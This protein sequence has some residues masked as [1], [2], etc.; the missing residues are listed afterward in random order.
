MIE[1]DIRANV[2][3]DSGVAAIVGTRM[4]LKKPIRKQTAPYL[5]YYRQNKSR[6]MVSE[7]NRFQIVA[8]SDD[9]VQLETLC[10]AVINSLE[11][12]K[13]LNGNNYHSNSLV[14]QTD[15]Q[16]KLDDGFFWSI[17]TF[18]FKHTT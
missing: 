15:S 7:K 11:G 3:G 4:F 5:V 9:T 2:L 14:G 8:F 12:K 17:L 6:D 1:I 10:T 18:E 13:V 16:D